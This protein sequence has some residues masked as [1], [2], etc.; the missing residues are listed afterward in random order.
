VEDGMSV[1]SKEELTKLRDEKIKNKYERILSALNEKESALEKSVEELE[2]K[3]VAKRFEEEILAK[4]SVVAGLA[5]RKVALERKLKELENK[6]VLEGEAVKQTEETN[7]LPIVVH[8][9]KLDLETRERI[10]KAVKEPEKK[11]FWKFSS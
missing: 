2:E 6:F 11:R 7:A 1:E 8:V 10:R 4:Q 3:L 5:V 9:P